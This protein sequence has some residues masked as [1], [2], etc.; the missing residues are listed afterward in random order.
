MSEP[1]RYEVTESFGMGDMIE[2]SYGNWVKWEAYEGL[3]KKTEWQPIE[4]APK[5]GT[6]IFIWLTLAGGWFKRVHW[7]AKVSAWVDWDHGEEAIYGYDG[8]KNISHWM[9]LPKPPTTK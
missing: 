1:K 8:D 3:K 4:T 6:A 7:S 9:P 2:S 5:D